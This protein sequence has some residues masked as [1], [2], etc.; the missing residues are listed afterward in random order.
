MEIGLNSH[1][2]PNYDTTPKP[3]GTN[4]DFLNDLHTSP[5]YCNVPGNTSYNTIGAGSMNNK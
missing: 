4:N 3:I 5:T 2:Q 1:S